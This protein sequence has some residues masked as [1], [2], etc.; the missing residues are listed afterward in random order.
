MHHSVCVGGT[1]ILRK[2]GRLA[3]GVRRT[4]VWMI[5]IKIKFSLYWIRRWKCSLRWS[6]SVNTLQIRQ[7]GKKAVVINDSWKRQQI[8]LLD[9]TAHLPFFYGHVEE[10]I[11]VFI[12]AGVE[13]VMQLHGLSSQLL[14]EFFAKLPGTLS[15]QSA[16]YESVWSG[17]RRKRWGSYGKIKGDWGRRK[18]LPLSSPLAFWPPLTLPIS[19]ICRMQA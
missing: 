1:S 11:I 8:I 19:L 12:T 16:A 10:V 2:T 7:N 6:G 3:I 18:R 15:L 14:R 13:M 17:R 9:L 5:N 4:Y